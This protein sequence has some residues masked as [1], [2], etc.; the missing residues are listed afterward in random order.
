LRATFAR[1][2]SS[3]PVVLDVI[4][5]RLIALL[6]EQAVSLQRTAFSPGVREAGDCS[7]GFFGLDGAMI[8]QAVTGT[9]GHVLALPDCVK[10]LISVHPPSSLRPGDVILTNDPYRNC[11]HQF[12]ITALTPVFRGD[13]PVALYASTCHVLDIGGS[14]MSPI[15][16]DVFEE[17]L[18][19]PAMKLYR[20]G[21]LN[22][23]L[24]QVI[25]ANVRTPVEVLGDIN[26]L[27]GTNDIGGKR[28]L[29]YMEEL[30]ISDLDQI[31]HEILTRSERA[32]RAAIAKLPAGSYSHQITIDGIDPGEP[33][34]VKVRLDI[35]ADGTMHVD[36]TGTSPKS[37]RANNVVLNYT[38]AYTS[39]ALKCAIAPELPNNAGS[40]APISVFAPE[41]SIL[42]ARSPSPIG[43]RSTVGHFLP[44]AIF[45]ALGKAA[46]HL[47]IAGSVGLASMNVYGEHK[48]R[49]FIS[50]S[51]L[52][53]GGMGARPTKDGLGA[54]GWPH[55]ARHV[56]VEISET[57]GPLLFLR[58]ELRADSG[59]PGRFRGGL[60]QTYELTMLSDTPTMLRL[61]AHCVEV[62][63]PG[64]S[65]GGA[66]AR[67]EVS[68]GD[69]KEMS[70]RTPNLLERGDVVR[71]AM[72]GGGGYEDPHQRDV[73]LVLADVLD[74]Y[75]TV[76]RAR[77]EYGVAIDQGRIDNAATATLR[78]RTTTKRREGV[79]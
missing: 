54:A 53:N 9:P 57:T 63:A 68:D 30:G 34:T 29:E 59:G 48:G 77:S 32:M 66:G 61:I 40:L 8:A 60:G 73:A 38:H 14:R 26:A 47:V 39:Y 50:G 31:Q 52:S 49:R 76:E 6:N 70:L 37:H 56:P 15:A 27:V 43:M 33:V 18:L 23:D 7:V 55:G 65:G 69:G 21:V 46:P 19:I 2:L 75:V 24:V 36:Y 44:T 62:P 58:H 42:Q 3:D 16:A 72:G 17:G 79:G 71:L 35:R 1:T 10:Y 5:T 41:G 12:D 74:G 64:S 13:V 4:W 78:A 67:G 28:V 51:G 25:R 20:G 22:E 11:G 45:G